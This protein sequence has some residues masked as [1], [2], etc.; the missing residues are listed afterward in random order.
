MEK[1]LNHVELLVLYNFNYFLWI[2][3]KLNLNY[4]SRYS[5][6][7][8]FPM[9]INLVNLTINAIGHKKA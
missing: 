6:L 5:S 7:A 8:L 4:I 9:V 3:L 1:I 2:P